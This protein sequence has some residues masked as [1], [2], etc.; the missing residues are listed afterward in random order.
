M[1][2]KPIKSTFRFR[3]HTFPKHEKCVKNG[4]FLSFSELNNKT[5]PYEPL[6]T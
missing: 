1:E 4:Y 2:R 5:L 3:E 6:W